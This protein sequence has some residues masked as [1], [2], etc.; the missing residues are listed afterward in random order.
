MIWMLQKNLRDYP[1]LYLEKIIWQ[2]I[3]KIKYVAKTTA[4]T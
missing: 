3:Y 2:R 1:T 4:Y